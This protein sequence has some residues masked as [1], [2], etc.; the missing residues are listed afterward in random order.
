VY[1]TSPV[2]HLRRPHHLPFSLF[3]FLPSSA[4]LLAQNP[5]NLQLNHTK[6]RFSIP[7]DDFLLKWSSAKTSFSLLSVIS[8]WVRYIYPQH[9]KN[10][11]IITLTGTISHKT[12][13]SPQHSN[14]P[15]FI[16][17]I[18]PYHNLQIR[19]NDLFSTLLMLSTFA[20]FSPA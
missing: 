4:S 11:V 7:K 12:L 5:P 2:N 6:I 17:F 15:L 18:L 13:I 9:G 20:L 19:L 1:I 14:V 3:F 10:A 16:F 8:E